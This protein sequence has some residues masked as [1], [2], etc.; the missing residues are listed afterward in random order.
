MGCRPS[1]DRGRGAKGSDLLAPNRIMLIRHAEKPDGVS[2]APGVNA[3]GIE[4]KESLTVRGWQRAGAMVRFFCPVSGARE[5]VPRTVFASGIGPE[6]KSLRPAE[7]VA[8]L[9]AFL[10]K[11]GGV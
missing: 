5:L 4:D 3:D 2:G 9:I 10:K 6:S 11:N 8:P 1:I 7:T